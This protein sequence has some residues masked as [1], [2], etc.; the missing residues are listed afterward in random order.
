MLC[1]SQHRLI[2]DD[3]LDESTET[4][5]TS[6]YLI[7]AM[8]WS[9]VI[10]GV[11]QEVQELILNEEVAVEE[12]KYGADISTVRTGRGALMELSAHLLV[13]ADAHA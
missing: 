1:A 4:D 10:G 3:D 8:A 2:Y 13:V 7:E 5:Q 12:A 6:C 9:I 11:L